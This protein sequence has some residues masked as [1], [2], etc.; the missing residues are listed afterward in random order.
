MNWLSKFFQEEVTISAEIDETEI[1]NIDQIFDQV[2]ASQNLE[3]T[4]QETDFYCGIC[5]WSPISTYPHSH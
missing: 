4:G 3:R 2:A 5:G 1:P